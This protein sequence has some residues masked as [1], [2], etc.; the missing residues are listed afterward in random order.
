MIIMIPEHRVKR[1]AK[2]LQKVL[3]ILEVNFRYT[4]CLELAAR[5]HGFE[6]WYQYLHRDLS[7]PLS[8]LDDDL[9]DEDFVA[10]DAFQVRVLEAAGLG[11]IARELLDR[12]NPTG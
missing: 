4:Q 5:L 11:T 9:S 8:P 7:Q 2:R 12:A 10:R 3:G 1:T 6:D